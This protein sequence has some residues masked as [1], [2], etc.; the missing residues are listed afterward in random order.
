MVENTSASPR[1]L[2]Y[3]YLG[4][5]DITDA[6][7]RNCINFLAMLAQLKV[8]GAG[9]L[10]FIYLPSDVADNGELAQYGLAAEAARLA[11]RCRSSP[12]T[13]T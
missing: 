12:E 11:C 13:T 1:P 3:A 4:Y 10:D 5:L 7:A 6:K 2:V 8:E 9:Q